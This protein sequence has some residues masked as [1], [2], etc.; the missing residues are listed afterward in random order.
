ME[1]QRRAATAAHI[2]GGDVLAENYRDGTKR[3]ADLNLGV[4]EAVHDIRD[5]A[6]TLDLLRRHGLRRGGGS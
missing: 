2:F 6:G 4:R 1:Q 3:C 5:D